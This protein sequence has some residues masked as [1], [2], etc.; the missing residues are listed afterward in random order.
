M[1]IVERLLVAPDLLG[2]LVAFRF[3][4]RDCLPDLQLGVLVVCVHLLDSVAQCSLE[5]IGVRL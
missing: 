3:E 2:G 1:N 4:D 5:C